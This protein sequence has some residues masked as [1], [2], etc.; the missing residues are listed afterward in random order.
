M[1]L[2]EDMAQ[3]YLDIAGV[4]FIAIGADQKVTLVTGKDARS[5]VYPADRIV[6]ANW[7]DMFIPA[8]YQGRSQKCFQPDYEGRDG[9]CRI[10]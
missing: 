5:W 9:S 10:F 1:H 8:K 4:M 7:F 6:G 3:K 2:Q